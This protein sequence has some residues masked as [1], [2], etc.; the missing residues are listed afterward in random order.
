MHEFIRT[1]EGSAIEYDWPQDQPYK[2]LNFYEARDTLLFSEREEEVQSCG[3]LLSHPA[4]KMLLIHGRTGTGK[5]SFL[6][7][8][9]F[10]QVLQRNRNLYVITESNSTEPCF[11]RSTS[12]PIA[13]ISDALS[14]WLND[15]S[16]FKSLNEDLRADA[17]A[18]LMTKTDKSEGARAVGL[19]RTLQLVTSELNGTLVVVIDQAEEVFT[20]SG[21]RDAQK[22]EYFDFL[23]RLCFDRFDIKVI[24]S[25]RTEYYGQFADNFRLGPNLTVSTVKSGLEQFM[26]H[27]IRDVDRLE[28]AI[29]RPTLET[30]VANK[31]SRRGT[32][33][34]LFLR[35][36]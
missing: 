20:L 26:L 22:R 17:I 2:G 25:L 29:L 5:S 10:P 28:K 6:R 3:K 14:R 7:A 12:D 21:P 32:S 31:K 35:K 9:L 27:G 33:I 11:I 13:S 19:Q 30:S 1:V 4:T 34:S 16:Q 15:R 8:G 36:V 18:S 24:I 23:E